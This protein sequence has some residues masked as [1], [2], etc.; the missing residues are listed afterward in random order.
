[1][2]VVVVVCKH[3]TCAP[4]QKPSHSGLVFGVA[5]RYLRR[6]SAGGLWAMGST[7]NVVMRGGGVG[8]AWLYGRPAENRASQ[9]RFWSGV[10]GFSLCRCRWVCRWQV[11]MCCGCGGWVFGAGRPRWSSLSLLLLVYIYC[12][13]NRC[14]LTFL[15][16]LYP[17]AVTPPSCI[18][19]NLPRGNVEV[20]FFAE[21]E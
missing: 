4:S 2:V 15:Y 11:M 10:H 16:A 8:R 9:A 5:C 6:T 3:T 17:P 14:L 21:E 1:V 20:E 12:F 13:G 19:C 18:V 7:L